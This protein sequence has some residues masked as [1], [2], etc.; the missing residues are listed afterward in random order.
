M[1]LKL[2]SDGTRTWSFSSSKSRVLSAKN[3]LH[4]DSH[5]KR[6]PEQNPKKTGL[7]KLSAAVDD[8]RKAGWQWQGLCPLQS[9]VAPTIASVMVFGELAHNVGIPAMAL[10]PKRDTGEEVDCFLLPSQGPTRRRTSVNLKEILSPIGPS[11]GTLQPP[12]LWEIHVSK[13]PS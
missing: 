10:A 3:T 1:S 9:Q 6:K 2:G 4:D 8:E 7:F 12:K 11:S 13:P 5:T